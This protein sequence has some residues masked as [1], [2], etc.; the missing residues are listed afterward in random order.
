ML[1]TTG[2]HTASARLFYTS[3]PK[4]PQKPA[5]TAAAAVQMFADDDRLRHWRAVNHE[6]RTHRHLHRKVQ[7]C[8]FEK[9]GII[10]ITS[11]L[12]HH[13]DNWNLITEYEE[14]PNS[15]KSFRRRRMLQRRT[16]WKKKFSQKS[17]HFYPIWN[18]FNSLWSIWLF[19]SRVKMSFHVI[20]YVHRRRVN[21]WLLGLL[22]KLTIYCN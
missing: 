8:V 9:N 15:E 11:Q 1:K 5:A 20:Q 12:V 2:F 19:L 22:H 3:H 10:S 17:T 4:R 14:I 6:S 13:I 18:E 16:R 7:L 21:V